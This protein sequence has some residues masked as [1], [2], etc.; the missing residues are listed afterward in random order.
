MGSTL[1]ERFDTRRNG[2]DLLR[3]AF[4]LLVAG[5]HGIALHTG[6]QPHW[7]G[8]T[9]G[10][11]GLDG[12]FIL[13]GFL[14]TRSY[15]SL[16]S[17]PRFA[18]HR[19]LRIMP[20]FWVCLLVVALVVAPLAAVLQGMP[21]G[22]PFGGD[23]SAQQYL[24]GNAALLITQYDIAG[25]LAGNPT[26]A[27]FNGS[28]WTLAFEALCYLLLAAIGVLG[29]LRRRPVAV[30]VLAGM[31]SVLTVAQEAGLPVLLNDRVLRLVFVFLLG[32][33]A[34]R[35]ADRI[36]MRAELAAAAACLFLVSVT[37]FHDYRVLGAAPLAYVFLW[38]GTSLPRPWRMRADLSYGLYIYH[39]PV[40][41]LLVLTGLAA[42][43]TALFVGA[44]LTLALLPAAASWYLVERR[45]LA[46]KHSTLPDR[47]AA[48]LIGTRRPPPR[49]AAPAAAHSLSR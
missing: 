30:A 38:L 41:Q 24:A 47:V 29:V 18:W 7:G 43:P 13:S 1:H 20:G 49:H 48:A 12:F 16:G 44:G 8:A 4:A 21:V 40:L 9:L 17:F 31:L 34:Y 2:F 46:H 33:V 6:T 45:A 3:M 36:P 14:V 25:I 22:T 5:T 23:A 27:S 19:L 11:F 39:W 35:Y 32:S 10:D 42:A 26:P 37:A 28:V 15:L